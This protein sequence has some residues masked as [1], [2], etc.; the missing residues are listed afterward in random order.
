MAD[1]ME[2]HEI[3]I[4]RY[5]DPIKVNGRYTKG[6]PLIIAAQAHIQPLDFMAMGGDTLEPNPRGDN[7]KEYVWLFSYTEILIGDI[8]TDIQT[9]EVFRVTK[10]YRW[11]EFDIGDDHFEV[12][13]VK[14]DAL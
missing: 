4:E 10:S 5:P 6:T 1:L 7:I 3:S 8:V 9:N 13:M 2:V 11:K 12:I 14:E